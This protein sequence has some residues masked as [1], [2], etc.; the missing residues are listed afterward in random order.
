MFNEVCFHANEA[1]PSLKGLPKVHGELRFALWPYDGGLV[2]IAM[3]ME[4]GAKGDASVLYT[5]SSRLTEYRL[6]PH[7]V[8]DMM[9]RLRPRLAMIT[10]RLAK[11]TRGVSLRRPTSAGL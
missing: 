2:I 6:E 3:I 10:E 9:D 11:G 4:P 8:Q 1:L 7:E 5:S